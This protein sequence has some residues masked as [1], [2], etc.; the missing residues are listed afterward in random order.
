MAPFLSQAEIRQYIE[1]GFLLVSGLMS[2][3]VAARAEAAMWR[4]LGMDASDPN[5][6]ASPGEYAP[7]DDPAMLALYT[8]EFL[9]VAAQLGEGVPDMS[10]YRAPRRLRPLNTYPQD[11]EWA[12]HGPHLD[13]AIKEHGH[14]TFPFA[15]RVATMTYLNDVE[16][17]G[18]ATV[19]WPGSHHRMEALAY[20]DPSRYETMW[21]LNQDI[22]KTDIGDPVEVIAARGDVLFYHVFT[23]HCGSRNVGRKP[24]FAFNMKW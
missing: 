22:G 19:V 20:A 5:T 16:S 8:S 4:N 17:H 11:G 3:D 24:R 6:W 1:Q 10:S 2:D 12:P 15:F 9:T 13:H 21:E 14:R 23:A 18:G 7:D